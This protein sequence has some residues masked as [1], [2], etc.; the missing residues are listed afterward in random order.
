MAPDTSSSIATEHMPAEIIQSPSHP[1]LRG[2]IGGSAHPLSASYVSSLPSACHPAVYAEL[3]AKISELAP[4]D[5]VAPYNDE[6]MLNRVLIARNLHAAEA[7]RMWQNIV[8]W[9]KQY[10]PEV[11]S[12]EEAAP[13]LAKGVISTC[14]PDKNGRPCIYGLNRNHVIDPEHHD[15]NLRT[16]INLLE[17]TTLESSETADGYIAVILDQE[18]V[19]RKNMDTNLFIAKP[20]LVQ[21]LQEY[22]PERLGSCYIIH[23]SWI[24]RLMWAIISPFLDDKTRKKVHVLPH[25]EDL[26]NHFALEA[27]PAELQAKLNAAAAKQKK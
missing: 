22:Y 15:A 13:Y 9:R 17:K 23:T 14:G 8:T 11:L 3:L 10:Q 6:D 25:T 21:A 12:E 5:N 19:G 2:S 1:S 27:L 26:L 4:E 24:F 18:G 20:G 7:F 16:I